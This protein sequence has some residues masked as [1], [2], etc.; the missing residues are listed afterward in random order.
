MKG[1]RLAGVAVGLTAA[2][3]LASCGEATSGGDD[4]PGVTVTDSAGTEIVYSSAPFW[5][6]EDPWTVSE[7]PTLR[8]GEAAGD[9]A[10]TLYNV[11][12]AVRL[13]DGRIAVVNSGTAQVRIYDETGRHVADLGR[14]GEGPGEFQLLM[15]LWS[16]RGDS[17][18]A[19]DNRLGR[20]T[21]FDAGG[22]VGRTIRLLPHGEPPR[23]SGGARST[24]AACSCPVWSRPPRCPGPGSSMAA[25]G[26]SN[27]I[28]PTERT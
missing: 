7:A 23:P 5:Q 9:E 21:V 15:D 3:A 4:A 18:V 2:L 6:A 13:R 12:A 10:Y 25:C 20:L 19:A 28:P 1:S 11:R 26:A 14:R 22:R 27:A 8:I 17:I 24:T 16:T